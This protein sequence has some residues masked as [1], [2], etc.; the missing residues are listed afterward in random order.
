MVDLKEKVNEQQ[1]QDMLW[2]EL[3]A[4]CFS[5]PSAAQMK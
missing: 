4:E 5:W 3:L 1:Q 2:V